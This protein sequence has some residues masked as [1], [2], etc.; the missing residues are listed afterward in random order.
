MPED[1]R[2]CSVCLD[3][4]A[5]IVLISPHADLSGFIS[6]FII[7][8]FGFQI[9]VYTSIREFDTWEKLDFVPNVSNKTSEKIRKT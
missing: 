5:A 8:Q 7:H 9:L 3:L 4:R 2:A 6:S 1:L